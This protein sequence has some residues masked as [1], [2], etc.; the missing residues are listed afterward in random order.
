MYKCNAPFLGMTVDPSGQISPC[1]AF[2]DRQH[3]NTSI[4]DVDNLD[5]FF[6]S[7]AYNTLRY[8]ILTKGV[9][10][11]PNCS[12]CVN[13]K[14]DGWTEMDNYNDK[15]VRHPWRVRYL[16]ITSSNV[17]N[18]S[19]VTCSSYFSSKWRKIHSK[20]HD[21]K[22]HDATYLNDDDVNKILEQVPHLDYIQLKGG[23]P[24]ADKNNLRI[25]QTLAEI[26]PSCNVVICS[27]M[28]TVSKEWYDVFAKLPNIQVAASVDAVDKTYDW[29]RG[30]DYE[31]TVFNIRE[32][33]HRVPDGKNKITI[34]VCVSIYN[35]FSLKEIDDRLSM[36]VREVNIA[37]NV[38]SPFYL[39]PLLISKE[40]LLNTLYDYYGSDS[41]YISANL[42]NL[43]S[44]DN[45]H[46]PQQIEIWKQQFFKHTEIMNVHRGHDIFDLQPNIRGLL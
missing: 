18:Q 11:I 38:I 33:S 8:Q 32:F 21:T 37:N 16:E 35:L 42:K 6:Q 31:E 46:T 36:Y 4:S 12:L 7:T 27:N 40:K 17:C 26:N 43:P 34:N 28:Q 14:P 9:D 22:P 1:C 30:G 19:C 10:S 13:A 23:E 45:N 5:T 24:T 2:Y 44:L 41:K 20:F 25:L 3:F 29:I 39:S 15:R